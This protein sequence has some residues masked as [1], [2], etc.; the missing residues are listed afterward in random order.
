[1]AFYRLPNSKTIQVVAQK[2]NSIKTVSIKDA[3]AQ[4]FLFAPFASDKK[5]KPVLIQSDIFCSEKTLPAL[6]FARS[7]WKI[8]TTKSTAVASSTRKEFEILV[9]NIKE[10]INK[11]QFQKIVA[12]RVVLKKRERRFD[13][14][15]FFQSLCGEYPSAFVS[16]V[17]IPQ[18]GLWVGA[19]PE[20]LL[21]VKNK[22]ARIFS[23]AGT[24]ADAKKEWTEKEFEE[25]G[26][27]TSYITNTFRSSS[28]GTP[29]VKGPVTTK[30][31]N[32]FHLL[33]VFTLKSFEHKN[34]LQAVKS[35][36][37]TPAVAGLPKIK[38]V[39]YILKNEKTFR[40]F[41]SGYLGP[42]NLQTEINLFVNIRCLQVLEKNLAIYTGCGVTADSNARRE[43]QETEA[44]AETLL[45]VLK[46][47]K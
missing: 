11:K 42:L 36:H 5:S 21:H 15:L 27:V 13:A 6:N 3:T 46:K 18:Y 26:L 38:A 8:R 31:G 28:L 37:P 33:T 17:F 43:W 9:N 23:L 1:M 29:E 25:Q 16:L 39:K 2:T 45:R 41:Y 20:V 12:A 7:K 47:Q 35:L 22:Q 24:K 32:L 10:E 14:V 40:D 30:A 44:K 4:G 34:W 19:T